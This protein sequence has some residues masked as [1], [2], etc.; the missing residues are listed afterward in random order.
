MM[1]F[2]QF[3]QGTTAMATI[4]SSSCRDN[5]DNPKPAD[6]RKNKKNVPLYATSCS[7]LLLFGRADVVKSRF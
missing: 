7:L 2:S 5:L 3:A 6:V 1:L 4:L